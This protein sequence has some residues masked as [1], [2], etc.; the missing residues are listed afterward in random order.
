[1]IEHSTFTGG[2]P[3]R[4]ALQE[5]IRHLRL[6]ATIRQ[7]CANITASDSLSIQSRAWVVG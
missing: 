7:R 6:P 2:M 5:A 3:D 1:L 4:E